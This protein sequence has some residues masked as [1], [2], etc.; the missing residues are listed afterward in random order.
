M[1]NLDDFFASG[2]CGGTT[3]SSYTFA[4]ALSAHLLGGWPNTLQCGVDHL[5]RTRISVKSPIEGQ[6]PVPLFWWKECR[7]LLRQNY[8]STGLL[9]VHWPTLS[10][11]RPSSL[12]LFFHEWGWRKCFH[13]TWQQLSVYNPSCWLLTRIMVA[14]QKILSHMAKLILELA[15][16]VGIHLLMK[17]LSTASCTDLSCITYSLDDIQW[18]GPT[19]KCT[20]INWD[21]Y[22]GTCVLNKNLSQSDTDV[23]LVMMLTLTF[24]WL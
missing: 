7:S 24:R 1:A 14:A 8:T 19:F 23:Q 15:Q 16:I 17:K 4:S 18:K 3:S 9:L 20:V 10:W 22:D 12:L 6:H 11:T 13:T 5:R 2:T 21:C